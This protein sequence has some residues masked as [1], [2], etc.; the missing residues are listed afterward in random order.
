MCVCTHASS[1]RFYK[2][3]D[4]GSEGTL[5]RVLNLHTVV[6]FM[7]FKELRAD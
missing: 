6:P 7:H 3:V 1:E 5:G 2:C 4:K